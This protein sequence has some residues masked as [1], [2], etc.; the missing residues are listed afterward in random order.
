MDK[1][2]IM[3]ILERFFRPAGKCQRLTRPVWKCQKNK[4]KKCKMSEKKSILW[5]LKNSSKIL[6]FIHFFGPYSYIFSS[7]F[8]IWL[9][10]ISE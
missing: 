10:W 6:N 8:K 5:I 2:L 1:I 9:G 3:R 7:G 4:L